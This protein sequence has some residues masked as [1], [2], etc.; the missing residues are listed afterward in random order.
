MKNKHLQIPGDSLEDSLL[1]TPLVELIRL[2]DIY[3]N[4]NLML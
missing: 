2:M 4:K 1:L 3:Q